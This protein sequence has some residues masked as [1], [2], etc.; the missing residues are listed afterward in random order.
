MVSLPERRDHPLMR[1]R[2]FAAIVLTLV[3]STSSFAQTPLFTTIAGEI[4]PGAL[5]EIAMP[6]GVPWNGELVVFVHGITPPTDPIALPALGALRN[7]LASQGFAL[8]YSSFSQS[9]YAVKDGFQRTHQLQG[10][11]ASTVGVPARV[12]LFGRSLGGLIAV[13]LAER[14]P[15]QYDGVLS[16]CGLLGGGAAE[17][18]YIVDGRVLFDYFFPGLVPGTA[19]DVPPDL[20][21]SPGDPLFTAVLDGLTH[22]LLGPDQPTLQLAKTAALP[23]ITS[24][25]LVS[26]GMTIV[27]FSVLHTNALIDLVHGHIPYDNTQ[28]TYV[29]SGND[30]ALNDAVERYASDPSAVNYIE[31]YGTPTGGLQVPVLAMHTTRDPTAPLFH[32]TM[33]KKLVDDAGASSFLLQRTVDAYGHCGFTN[34]ATTSAFTALV[35]WVRTGV[36]PQD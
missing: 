32:E 9:G 17:L 10:I 25:E 7:T 34:A 3:A 5:Y 35:R 20:G 28:S 4:G 6:A 1:K 29:G 27:S 18:Q 15:G 8:I 19:L 12:Y 13:L 30:K 14:F 24:S 33:F 26:S 36:K 31:H 21:F 23:G 2:S 22:G 11:F 16:Q